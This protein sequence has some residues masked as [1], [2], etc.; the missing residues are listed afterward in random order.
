MLFIINV[1]VKAL[2][3][4]GTDFLQVP[5]SYY[6]TL[7]ENLKNSKVKV[8]EDLDALE[9]TCSSYARNVYQN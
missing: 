6:V 2:K 9:V 5:K 3:E 1:Q 4:R 8:S 7:R